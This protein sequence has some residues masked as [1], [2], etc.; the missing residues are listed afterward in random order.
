MLFRAA[1]A[2]FPLNGHIECDNLERT[3]KID[4][5]REKTIP[6]IHEPFSLRVIDPANDPLWRT[7]VDSCP[8]AGLFH[9]P[10]WIRSVAEGYGFQIRSLVAIGSDDVLAGGVAFCELDDFAGPR[11]VG[12][13]FGDTCD[14]LLLSASAWPVL[15]TAL[16]SKGLPVNFRCLD[17]KLV[18]A[19]PGI[20]IVKKARWHRIP[21]DAPIEEVW[22]RLSPETKRAIRKSERSRLDVRALSGAADRGRFHQLHVALRKSK[23]RLLAQPQRFLEALEHRF[24]EIEGWHSL[25]AFV[26]SRMIAATIYLRWRD[27][28]YYKFNASDR[29]NLRLRP[30]NRLVW[31]GI[32]V[33]R[34]LG[35][36]YLDLGPSDDDQP[37]LIHFKR[38]FGAEEHELTFLRWSPEGWEPSHERRSVLAALTSSLTD[39]SVSDDL[40]AQAGSVLYRFF[41]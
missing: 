11:L 36:R 8:A 4:G 37:G 25:G 3:N 13:P 7:L 19:T 39:P 32:K 33:A 27:T 5:A 41:A 22:R 35:C 1:K 14:P 12:V 23:Y 28:L 40:A 30:N 16:Q 10:P 21:I 26:D 6:Q 20:Q 15:L 24:R 34:A 38:S 17:D 29:E 2:A 9:S 31:E 18:G